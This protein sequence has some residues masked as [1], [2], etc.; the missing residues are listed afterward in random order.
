[1]GRLSDY[2][3]SRAKRSSSSSSRRKA[4][5]VRS[6]QGEYVEVSG[7]AE[8]DAM[9]GH[10]MT[11]D[12]EMTRYVRRQIRQVLKEARKKL[13]KD[14]SN[15]MKSD[16]KKAA[17]AVKFS[18]Y[19]T[20]FGGNLSILQRGKAGAN[21]ELNRQRKVDMNPHQRGGNRIPR[22]KERNRLDYYYGAQR[23]F[24][25]RFI[26]SGTETRTTRYGN[27]GRIRRSDWFGRTAP[28]QIDKAAGDVA[29][30]ISQ[31]IKEKSNG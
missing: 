19:K 27:R 16:P 31:Y 24:I 25:L 23:G 12:P 18:V 5:G 17:R 15:Y 9:L 3:N 11:S 22:Q 7:F 10:M 26:S 1:M 29:D 30:A 14:A 6:I 13:S 28:W 2:I 8:N 4:T 21:Y 20:I